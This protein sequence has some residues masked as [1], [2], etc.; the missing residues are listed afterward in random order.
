M[1]RVAFRL[2]IAIVV[3]AAVYAFGIDAVAPYVLPLP[4][5]VRV[6]VVLTATAPLGF[7]LGTFLPLGVSCIARKVPEPAGVVAWGWATNGFFSVIGSVAT[8]ILAMTF[9]F[10]IVLG[11]AALTYLLAIAFLCRLAR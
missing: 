11:L 9:G 3:L 5:A 10:R 2:A 8:A 1:P 6:G 7:V 4:L